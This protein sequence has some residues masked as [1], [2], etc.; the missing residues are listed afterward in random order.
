MPGDNG[1]H[2]DALGA[3]RIW[4]AR[5]ALHA[6]DEEP[7][8]LFGKTIGTT[9]AGWPIRAPDFTGGVTMALTLGGT[10]GWLV[11]WLVLGTQIR[12]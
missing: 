5:L 8:P 1:G 2:A 10:S 7:W 4:T 9:E 12:L 3:R 6:L 11:G